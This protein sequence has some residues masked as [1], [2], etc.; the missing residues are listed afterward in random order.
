MAT[1][2]EG[3]RRFAARAENRAYTAGMQ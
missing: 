2:F 3:R 1:P